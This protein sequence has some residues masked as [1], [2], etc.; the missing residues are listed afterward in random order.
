MLLFIY[1]VQYIID[2]VVVAFT[3]KVW[4]VR[5]EILKCLQRALSE[6]ESLQCLYVT[7]LQLSVLRMIVGFSRRDCICSLYTLKELS[8][9]KD[10][11]KDLRTTHVYVALNTSRV[12]TVIVVSQC[13]CMVMLMA[14]N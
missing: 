14:F 11:V 7:K 2:R 12:W 5:E 13:Y 10:V 6:Y 4:K 9:D 8:V 3:H 1:C